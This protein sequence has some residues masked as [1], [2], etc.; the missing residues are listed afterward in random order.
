MHDDDVLVTA[1]V[2]ASITTTIDTSV[3]SIS[4]YSNNWISDIDTSMSQ[5]GLIVNNRNVMEEIDELRDAVKAINSLL[6]LDRD[7]DLESK[8]QELA[9]AHKHYEEL[10][11]KLRTFD[12]LKNG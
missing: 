6:L 11:E 8:Y 4:V 10:R 2:D 9:D 3:S 5:D 7:K 12:L 1:S